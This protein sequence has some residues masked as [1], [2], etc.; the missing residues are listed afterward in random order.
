MSKKNKIFLIVF[1]VIII[2]SI[3]ARYIGIYIIDKKFEKDME[4]LNE[5]YGLVEEKT[6]VNI[7]NDFNNELQNDSSLSK[8]TEEN[9]FK[10]ED[11]TYCYLL[12]EGLYFMIRPIEYIDNKEKEISKYMLLYIDNS[13]TNHERSLEY[14]KR[15]IKSNNK[16]IT[17]KEILELLKESIEL[18][19]E[20]T[21]SN[22]SK[23]ISV[24]YLTEE[25]HHEIQLKRL[26]K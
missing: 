20:K 3:A 21:C 7:I 6:I 19:S 25:D 2:L 15:L 26:Y 24:C 17:D 13:Y 5:K 8:V 11:N 10:Q 4:A 16:D 9:S 1:L 14:A 12:E 23:G 22:N 18:S